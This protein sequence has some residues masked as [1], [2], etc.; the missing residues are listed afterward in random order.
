MHQVHLKPLAT[1]HFAKTLL[2]ADLAALRATLMVAGP[3]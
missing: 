1:R 3:R 2:A